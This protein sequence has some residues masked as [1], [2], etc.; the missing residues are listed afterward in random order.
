[1]IKSKL[2]QNQTNIAAVVSRCTELETSAQYFDR[3]IKQLREDFQELKKR[4]DQDH[5][6][7][8]ELRRQL[9][10]ANSKIQS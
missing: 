2:N 7:I 3:D 9:D 4:S 5:A 8:S 10:Y 1:M 6:L